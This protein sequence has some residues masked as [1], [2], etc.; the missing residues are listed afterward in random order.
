M[1][2]TDAWS[3]DGKSSRIDFMRGSQT[4]SANV[5]SSKIVSGKASDIIYLEIA[6]RAPQ[7]FTVDPG[8]SANFTTIA[9]ALFHARGGDTIILKPGRYTESVFVRPSVTIR[10][11]EK[12]LV[13]IESNQSWL[14]KGPGAFDISDII[15]FQSGLQ[16]ENTEKANLIGNTFIAKQK[17]TAIVLVDSSGVNLTGCNFQGAADSSGIEAY[18][19]QFTVSDSVFA[20]HGSWAISLASNSKGDLHKNLLQGNR[21]G[22]SVQESS[23]LAERNILA[24]TWSP[25]KE[26]TSGT[27]L[28]AEKATITFN[29]NSV[30]RYAR[31][32]L[33]VN[34]SVSAGISDNTVTQSQHAI[35]LLG[36]NANVTKNL[37]IQN[38]GDGVYIG[39][40]EKEKQSA[41]Q[42][43]TIIQNTIS[44]NETAIDAETFNHLTVKENLIEANHW[45][46]RVLHASISLENNTIVLQRSTAI[47]LGKDS[48]A[49]V[50]NNIVALNGFG[51]FAHVESHRESGYNDVFGNLVNTD[52]PLHDGNYGRADYYTTHDKR[53]V[54]IE[55]YP[56]YDLMPQTDLS[57]DPGFIKVGSDYT[58]KPT[59]PLTKIRGEG[60]H[61]L[62]AYPLPVS[63]ARSQTPAVRRQ[64]KTT[65]KH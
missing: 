36:S 3:Q 45:G 4:Q 1:S 27:G 16:L 41:P 28:R 39:M 18:G 14:L 23:L 62:G 13:R 38:S 60:G 22:I 46:V 25:D 59:S 17:M 11:S 37:V 64:V 40:P 57:V 24:G 54:P 63:Q 15:F 32:V 48:D 33:L 30:R 6:A 44:Q 61:Y 5:V 51:I 65:P 52:F 12:S 56:A 50:Y 29:K 58:L 34:T 7:T 26:N 2:V 21:N 53:K 35:I 20:E 19:S 47:N 8:G 49:R 31:G 10:P 43:V 42:E 9:G 55:V